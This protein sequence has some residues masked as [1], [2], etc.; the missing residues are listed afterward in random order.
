LEDLFREKEDKKEGKKEPEKKEDPLFE[1]VKAIK[2]LVAKIEPKL[3]TH[4]L[5]L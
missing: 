5:G 2:E 1:M 4:A 3:P